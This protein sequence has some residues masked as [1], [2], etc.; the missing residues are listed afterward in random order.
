MDVGIYFESNGHGTVLFSEKFMNAIEAAKGFV[1]DRCSYFRYLPISMQNAN[2]G[3][4]N[5]K[6]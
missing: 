1:E 6:V 4:Q 3:L 5:N 2:M